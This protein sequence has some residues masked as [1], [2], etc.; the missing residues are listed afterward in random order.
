MILE[1][2]P[3]WRF[4]PPEDGAYKNKEI[5][6]E[7]ENDFFSL[8]SKVSSQGNRQTILEHFKSHFCHSIGTTHVWSSSEGWAESDLQA[9][10]HEA[11]SNAPVFID[12]LYDALVTLQ[13]QNEKY[14]V[15]EAKEL[16]R[17]FE[18]HRIGYQISGNSLILRDKDVP[19]V[20]LAA[21]VESLDEKSNRLI[22]NSLSKAEEM[23]SAGNGIS[24]VS[25]TL[26]LLETV[27]T[28][29]RGMTTNT[30]TIEGKYFN[31][32]VKEIQAANPGSTLERAL[33]WASSVHGYLSSPTGG[34]VRHGLD[35][36]NGLEL[37]SSE[38]RLFL[39]LIRS[40][41]GYLLSEHA[42][43]LR[44]KPT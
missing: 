2:D 44:E 1:F 35:L 42:R 9:F 41:I 6:P 11:A 4:L 10:M 24:A 34:G 16:N 23:I 37:S 31:R 13:N 36:K 43:I 14:Y 32:I 3:K 28:A 26:W 30:K 38:C 25:E 18:Q 5:P 21:K 27:S 29:F 33:E 7:A 15:P 19:K 17:L 40:Y 39:N 20:E 8:I 12:A 22:N